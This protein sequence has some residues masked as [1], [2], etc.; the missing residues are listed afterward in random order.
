MSAQT[1]AILKQ[2]IPTFSI[3]ADENRHEIL[4]L[5]IIHGKLNV[6]ELTE[7]IHLSRPAVSHHLKL[8]LQAGLVQVTQVGK[9]RYYFATLEDSALLLK[10]LVESLQAHC[11]WSG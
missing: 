4:D 1:K 9:E 5:L 8:M 6:N 10:A 2:C 3:L 11:G 7:K